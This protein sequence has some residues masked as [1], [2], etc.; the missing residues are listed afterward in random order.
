M[1]KFFK[2]FP[3][4]LVLLLFGAFVQAKELKNTVPYITLNNGIKMPQI[5]FG[6]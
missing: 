4:A 1:F 5:G 2:I 3:I 6:T